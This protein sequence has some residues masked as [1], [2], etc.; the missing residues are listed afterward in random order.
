MSSGD[1]DVVT[2]AFGYTG[3]YIT[4]RLLEHALV[5]LIAR[6]VGSRSRIVHVPTAVSFLAASAIGVGVRDVVVTRDELE[7][8]MA[9]L[10]TTD[11]PATGTRLL[12]EWLTENAD[13]VGRGYASEV[14]RH[15]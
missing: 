6:T 8:L 2:G 12:S 1:V 13:R 7:G 11:G 3:R 4:E 14:S 10:V 5:R 15:Y 9:N